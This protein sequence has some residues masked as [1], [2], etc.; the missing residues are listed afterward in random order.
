MHKRFVVFVSLAPALL[1][2]FAGC[3]KPAPEP[4]NIGHLAARGSSS[5]RAIAEASDRALILA[6]EEVK[7]DQPI[8]GREVMIINPDDVK[9]DDTFAAAAT[10]L[11]RV[12]GAVA[13]LADARPGIAEQVC[14]VA[15]QQ[16]VPVVTTAG[17]PGSALAPFAFS[18]G[19]SPAEQGKYL[20]RFASQE[21]KSQQ[22]WK[23]LHVAILLDTQ[24]LIG[25]P[26]VNAFN[27]E[28]RTAKEPL[29]EQFPF[30]KSEELAAKIKE[31][32]GKEFNLVLFVGTPEDRAKLRGPDA[33]G[34]DVPVLFGGEEDP[35]PT[36]A[37][38][39]R[40]TAYFVNAQTPKAEAFVKKYRERFH[41]SPE[42][43]AALAYDSARV[44]FAGL[45]E[46][47]S[48]QGP[49]VREELLKLKNF[50]S[51]TGPLSFDK[52]N[53]TRRPVFIVQRVPEEK[54][55]KDRK[56]ELKLLKRYDP[57]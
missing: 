54:E 6:A 13:L 35:T 55:A 42:A 16:S 43:T 53:N 57:E 20:A 48:M 31:M 9:A 40:A 1:L 44:T 29:P 3:A 19:L 4:L 10:R 38:L 50:D 47:K 37:H 39:Y 14:R 21:L 15:Q 52:D 5:E 24:L 33:L 27:D 8:P 34:A 17:L 45:R 28:L 7:D 56:G 22:K 11:I 46:A 41:E 51:L 36:D 49:K 2:G 23:E 25:Q 30:A 26:L 12:N 18:V 32:T